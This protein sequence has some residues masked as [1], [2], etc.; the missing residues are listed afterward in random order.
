MPYYKKNFYIEETINSIINQSYQK[1]EI[2]L[3]DDELSIESSEVLKKIKKKMKEL[4]LLII[5][6]I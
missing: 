6:I 1:F 5:K 2:I 3:I 4:K